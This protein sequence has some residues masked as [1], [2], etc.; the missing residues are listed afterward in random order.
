MFDLNYTH[1]VML[2]LQN[3]D[4]SMNTD[5]VTSLHAMYNIIFCIINK[6]PSSMVDECWRRVATV[7][8]R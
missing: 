4:H 1:C 3:G 6:I 8:S 5:S 7:T 2:Y